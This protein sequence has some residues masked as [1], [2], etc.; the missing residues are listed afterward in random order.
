MRTPM[1]L[2]EITNSPKT[3]YG[4]EMRSLYDA[5]ASVLRA[6]GVLATISRIS[7]DR[8]PRRSVILR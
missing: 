2:A 1:T 4:E 3:G 5:P 6:A 8:G 7:A